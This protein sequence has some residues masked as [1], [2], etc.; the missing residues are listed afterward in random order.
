MISQKK[1]EEHPF[2]D[3]FDE[4]ETEKDFL[5][6]KPVCFIIFGKPGAGKTTLANQIAQT[7]KCVRVEALP[8]LEEMIATESESGAMLRSMLISGNSVP[9]ELVTKL[10]L[11]KL[12]SS[13]VSHFGYIVTEIPSLSEDAMTVLQQVELIK[14]LKLKPDII[15][16]IRCPDYDLC[17]RISGQ[18]QHCNTGYVYTRDQWDPEVIE[19][20][21]K[22]KKDTHK[23]GK[24]EE[25]GEEE[26]E[27]E[28][29]EA[30]IAEMQM[31]AEIL[32]HLVQRPE[33]YLEN[34]ENIIQLYKETI[35]NCLEE[36]MAEH[37]P[38]FLIELDGNKP[39]E[40]LFMD[41]LFR[42]LSAYKLIA[43]RYRWRRSKWGR[44]C[45]V[46]LK[47]GNIYSGLPDFSVSFLGKIYCLSS[48]ETLKSF[49]LNPR[50]FLLP[51]MPIPPCKIF[52]F[53][54]QY[55][56]KTTLSHLIANYYKGKVID[57]T[58]VVQPIFDAARESLIENSIAE[59]TEAAIKVVKENLLAELQ[60]K[61]QDEKE[62]NGTSSEQR[63]SQDPIKNQNLN[64][65]S[66]IDAIYHDPDEELEGEDYD[67]HEESEVPENRPSLVPEDLEMPETEHK[68]AS[69]PS[70]DTTTGTEITKESKEIMES[71]ESETEPFQ[72]SAWELTI[73]DY[74]EETEDYQAE[75]DID[76]D[77]DEEEEEEEESEERIK[78]KRRH[79]GDTKS[80][81]PVV[82][83]ENFILQPCSTEE[84]AKY[85]EKFYYFSSA[86][87]R[88]KFQ[89]NPEDYVAHSEPLKA[90]PPRICLM[91]PR[92]SGKTVC[93]RHVAEKF[94]IFHIQFEEVLQEKL[95][96]KTER[97]FGPEY[98][99]DSDEE[100]V[101]KQELEE[102]AAQA[103]VK[104]EDE[105]AKTQ[106]PEVQLT[107]EEE[108]IKSSLV[109]SEPL[110][111]EILEVILSEWWL[112]EP[113]RSTG[114]ILDGFP[115][116]PEEALFLG[117]HGFFPDTAVFIQVDD[118]DIFD[119]LLPS[120][121]EK[122][123]QKQKKKLERKKLIKD[124]KTKIRDDNIAKRRAELIAEKDKRKK[125]EDPTHAWSGGLDHQ[126]KMLDLNTDQENFAGTHD[127][128]IRCVEYCPEVNVMVIGSWDQT[129]KL[130]DPR[131][132]CN[133]GTFSQP[134]KVYTLSVSGVWLIVGSAGRR[135]LVW[136]LRNMGYVQQRRESSLKYQTR[137]IR[138]ILNKQGYVLSS[139]EGPVAVEY[140]DPSPEV[141][142]KYAFKCHRLK[143]NNIEQIYPV[144]AISFHNIHNTFATGGSDG[145]VNIWDPF[146]KKRLCQ[147]QRYPTSIASLAFSNDGTTL[148]IASSY[149]YEMHDTEHPEDGIFIRQ[150]TDAET[151]PKSPCTWQ[152]FTYLSAMLMIIKQFGGFREDEEVSEEEPDDDE[153]DIEN[154]LEEEF[155]KDEEEMSEEDEEQEIDAID[156][157]RSELGE[158]FETEM[159][160]LQMI[161]DEFEKFLIPMI[162]I[163]GARKIHIVQY[164]LH[165]KLKPLVENRESIFEKCYP[166]STQLAQKMLTFTY[167]YISSFG[168]W[169]PVKLYE[170][171]IFKPVENAEN[172]LYPVIHRQYI[173]FLSS[174]ET[175]DKFMKNPIKYIRQPKPKLTVPIR[176]VIVGPPKSGKTTVAKKLASDYGLKHLS[177]GDAL[178]TILNNHAET[179][180]GLMLNWHLHKGMV[181][182]DELAI[183]ALDLALMD[184][185][186]N[187]SGVVI[188]GYPVTAYQMN[189][190]ETNSIIPMI[191]FE[192]DVPSK[193]IFKRLFLEKK[194]EQNLPYPLHNSAQIIA[195]KN[196]KY[197]KNIGEIRQYY[198]EQHQNWYV[199]DGLHSKWWVWNEVTK[200]I[201]MINKHMQTYLERI[202]EG[203]AAL[204]NKLCITPQELISRLGEFGQFCPVS[205]AESYEL[206]DC[207]VTDSL[208]FA[209]EFRGHYYKMSSQEKLNKFLEN[210]ELY[211]TPLAPH[212]LPPAD[213]I[214]KRLTLS[215]LKSRFPKCAE[216]QGYCP[217]TYQDGKQRYEA[218]VPGNINYAV[219]Y[220][221]RIYICESKEKLDK[222]L[223]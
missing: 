143:E 24:T 29:E 124:M 145:F 190:L 202:R 125:A 127:A 215:E 103:N 66:E 40:E 53:G 216:L 199:I 191:I 80:F 64:L 217:V 10:M 84:A 32:H 171:E 153:D 207:S 15:I 164:I 146:K 178:R 54:P 51:P 197:R 139:I 195:I 201:Y 59:A 148:A 140:L 151:N 92:G 147:F 48:E 184:S 209:A 93:G 141:Q 86:E 33:D 2:A 85:R 136:D 115:R 34:V 3:I 105:N 185:V 222:F 210:P 134:E 155:P 26:E 212:P 98:E 70:E 138:A 67:V 47:E 160:N 158:K 89:E 156:R 8:V 129:V 56:G 28:E 121:V 165:T 177:I 109:E 205:L 206:C 107:E 63:H 122:W 128:P 36:V 173:Y 221:D 79:L 27:Q 196:A 170:G 183:Q 12:N 181:A 58:T 49:L 108:I 220:R 135:V 45:P 211:V 163:N 9:D 72:Y 192:L 166:I 189:L 154:I 35:L 18:R 104:I 116:Y 68:L 218:L 214:P 101:A 176:I 126:L 88:E 69:E 186:C 25:E 97:K 142:K 168:Y 133:A 198:Q 200:K 152:D 188:D 119:R 131:T 7:W 118:Q 110:L 4:D 22:K 208:E 6:S 174:K 71:K 169:D 50:P 180:L 120:K 31:A 44:T 41:E 112:K 42:T 5:L 73:E 193:E 21:R 123:K 132:P 62:I 130:W 81:C 16:N 65:D 76:E 150:V 223:R 203:K 61:R 137:C 161:Q 187:T 1:T 13:E 172:P 90:P 194:S 162:H 106:P 167:K 57:Y 82:L 19:S 179:E 52:I 23:E 175:K 100:Q 96:L 37:N 14:N 144:N 99:E 149:M 77:L 20:H 75:A 74:D 111:P 46:A 17:Q 11:E 117:D 113:F 182:P 204:I 95:L 39:P 38:Q 91:G 87:A 30:F 157:L 219:E 83:K 159:S 114:F 60:A 213:R 55:S 94:G 78:E 43:P 102:L